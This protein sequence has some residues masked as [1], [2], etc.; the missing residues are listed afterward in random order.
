[1]NDPKK[2]TF[3]VAAKRFFYRNGVDTL[4]AFVTELKQLTIED[5]KEMAPMLANALNME[6]VI[7]D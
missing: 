4:P 3:A 6:E 7:V 2:C 5:K 1:M